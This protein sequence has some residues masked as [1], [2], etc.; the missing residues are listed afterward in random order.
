MKTDFSSFEEKLQ[1][2]GSSLDIS[3]TENQTKQFY[4]YLHLYQKWSK[5]MNLSSIHAEKEIIVK[6][7]ADSLV[8]V[9]LLKGAKIVAD[10]GSGA[11]FPG[12]PLK[13]VSP[14]LEM[15][16]FESKEKKVFFLKQ[17][18]RTLG[19][20]KTKVIHMWIGVDNQEIL[21]SVFQDKRVDAVF[22]RAIK[23]TTEMLKAL[24]PYLSER[25]CFYL[26]EGKDFDIEKL[27]RELQPSFSV[28]VAKTI[29]LDEKF[30]RK[31][32]IIRVSMSK[33]RVKA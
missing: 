24:Q 31:I 1:K 27:K 4:Q 6:H 18:V 23:P 32:L 21:H 7:F 9:S 5:T 19:L 16:L 10:I 14:A 26:Y 2:A 3:L 25:G 15:F 13:I 22:F 11:G 30:E 28:E 20:K 29:V 12:V 17:L 8:G 33:N